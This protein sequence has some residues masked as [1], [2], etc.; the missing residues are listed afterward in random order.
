MLSEVAA[1]FFGI[2]VL[3]LWLAVFASLILAPITALRAQKLARD[4]QPASRR[5]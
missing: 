1:L 4:A 5:G 2:A 3:A